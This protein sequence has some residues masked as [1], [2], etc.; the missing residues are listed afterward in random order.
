MPADGTTSRWRLEQEQLLLDVLSEQ[1]FEPIGGEGGGRAVYS[2]ELWAKIHR[3]FITQ[4]PAVNTTLPSTRAGMPR[5]SFMVED[6]NRR[7]ASSA[8]KYLLVRQELG[9]VLRPQKSETGQGCSGTPP[10]DNFVAASSKW[11]LFQ[12]YHNAFGLCARNRT[13]HSFLAVESQQVRKPSAT[14][15]NLNQSSIL[16][17][18]IHHDR[19]YQLCV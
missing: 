19:Y 14:G 2:A 10:A 3:R 4:L 8:K 1:E 17:S 18:S 13:E 6:L 11:G 7:S 15:V 9:M 12:A 5:D 16:Q